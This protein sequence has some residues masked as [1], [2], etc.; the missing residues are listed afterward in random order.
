MTRAEEYRYLA[1]KVRG[2]AR[3]E[4]SDLTAEWEQLARCYIL[5]AEH[6]ERTKQTD[7]ADDG[8]LP[9]VH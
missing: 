7:I 8:I 4:R 6:A 5:L 3:G 2:R 1:E 9:T